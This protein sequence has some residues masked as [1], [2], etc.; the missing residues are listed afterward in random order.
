MRTRG[1]VNAPACPHRRHRVAADPSQT[2]SPFAAEKRSTLRPQPQRQTPSLTQRCARGPLRAP[3][4]AMQAP[5]HSVT[6]LR[7]GARTRAAALLLIPAQQCFNETF[8]ETFIETCQIYWDLRGG[9]PRKLCFD[10]VIFRV[11]TA[12]QAARPSV[13]LLRAGACTHAAALRPTPAHL[14][15]SFCCR[16]GT[17][18]CGVVDP[19]YNVLLKLNF[20]FA[21]PR[22]LRKWLNPYQHSTPCARTWLAAPRS[23]PKTTIITPSWVKFNNRFGVSSNY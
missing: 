4:T 22:R 6:Q 15:I 1:S 2:T 23:A 10:R 16:Y 12:M 13:Y 5:R 9:G 11:C 8:I 7:A 17:K 19:E 3:R 20:E 21:P 14:G 18:H